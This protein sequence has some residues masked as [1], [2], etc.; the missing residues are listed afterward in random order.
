MA[1]KKKPKD[2]MKKIT[3]ESK[4]ILKENTKK[5]YKKIHFKHTSLNN[6]QNFHL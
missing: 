4:K 6:C 2:N 5:K 3:K 1:T